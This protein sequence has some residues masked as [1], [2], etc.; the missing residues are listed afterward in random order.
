V[1]ISV[2]DASRAFLQKVTS[3]I[4]LTTVVLWTLLNLPLRGDAELAA[5]GVDPTDDVAVTAFVLDN[6]AAAA[7]GRG[8]APVFDP[9]GFDWRVN[10][11]VISSLAAREVFVSTLGQMASASDPEDPAEALATMTHGPG[12]HEGEPVFTPPTI[13]ALMVFFVYAL[14][15]MS[16]L[17]VMRR[18]TG[19]W[20]WPLVAFGYMSV[21]AWLAAFL[22][23]TLVAALI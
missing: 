17:G 8:V 16:T 12:P 9:L 15:C 6:S 22:A 14:Q 2:W 13:A 11:G 4:L 1:L 21:V 20:K 3:I 19:T 18:E 7:V 23:H 10:V 5:A